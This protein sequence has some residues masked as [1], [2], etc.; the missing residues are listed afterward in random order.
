MKINH[1]VLIALAFISAGAAS[2][3]QVNWP[4]PPMNQYEILNFNLV[5]SQQQTVNMKKG[6]NVVVSTVNTFKITSKSLLN[7]L[8]TACNTNW[9]A[10]AH[11]ALSPFDDSIH[12]VDKTGTNSLFRASDGIDQGGTNV[13]FLRVQFGDFVFTDRQMT[14]R[15]TTTDSQTHYQ[16]VWFQL[17]SEQNGV[18]NTD[19]SFDGLDTFTSKANI[20]KSHAIYN[21][22]D[23]IS[24][25]GDGPFQDGT[26]TIVTGDVS[27][28][29]RW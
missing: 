6:A 10:G 8:A 2:R 4:L 16:K 15:N 22:G 19:L 23:D 21:Q 20:V 29:I 28:S 24:V 1:S 14:N 3:A 27:G 12:I 11:L 18:T 5:A 25:T 26:W 9:P 13:A 17:F 7:F